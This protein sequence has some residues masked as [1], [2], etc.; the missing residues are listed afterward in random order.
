MTTDT[1][2]LVRTLAQRQ[3][4]V[5]LVVVV[6]T[7]GSLLASW[8]LI[9]VNRDD[10]ELINLAGRQRMLSQRMALYIALQRREPD[11]NKQRQYRA[12]VVFA[13]AEFER[14]LARLAAAARDHHPNSAIYSLYFGPSGNVDAECR[15]YLAEVR[16]VLDTLA[17]DK[18]ADALRIEEV[19]DAANSSLLAKLDE[20]TELHQ[21]DDETKEARLFLILAISNLLIVGTLAFGGLGVFRPARQRLSLDVAARDQAERDLKASEERF[22]AFSECSSD[23]FWE[24]D[25]Q[26]RFTWIR[27]TETVS[28]PL[29][30]EQVRGKTRYELIDEIEKANVEKWRAYLADVEAHRPFR[31][32]EYQLVGNDRSRRWMSVSGQPFFDAAGN[33]L[34]Y[35]GT[36]SYIQA[37]KEIEASHQRLQLAIEQSPVAIMITDAQ[38]NIIYVNAHFSSISGYQADEA[39]GRTPKLLWS[40]DVEADEF[41]AITADLAAGKVWR[42]EMCNRHKN[43]N[44][45]WESQ[46]ISPVCD[47]LGKVTHYILVSEDI[48]ARRKAVR[49]EQGYNRILAAVANGTPLRRTL[50]LMTAMAE[51]ELP[52][53]ICSFL[54]MDPTQKKLFGASHSAPD[55]VLARALDEL[56]IGEKV[57]ACGTAAYTG[58]EVLVDDIAAHPD[59][60]ACKGAA[61]ADGMRACWSKPILATTG[62]VLGVLVIHHRKPC[63]PDADAIQVIDL[64]SGLA[65]ICLERDATEQSIRQQEEEARGLLAEHQ[66]IL[67]NAMVGIVYLKQRRVVSCNRRLEEIFGYGHGELIGE[68]SRIFYASQEAFEKI[69]LDAYRVV[70]EGANYSTELTLKRKDGSY[71]RGALNGRAIDPAQPQE[72]SIWVYADISERYRAE[73]EAHK[74]LQAVEQSP[75][76]IMITDTNGLIEYANPRFTSVTG[77]SLREVVGQNPRIL[78]SGETRPDTYRELWQA[79]QAGREW[80]GVLRNRRKNGELF[81]EEAS[82]SPIIDDMNQVTNY[83]AVKEDITQRKHIEDEL[84][85]HRIN[86]EYLV[87]RRTADLTAALEAAKVADQA[88]D[89]F[90]ANVS[91]ELRTPLNA[92]IGMSDLA[93]RLSTDPKQQDYLDK[94]AGAGKTLAGIIND[95]L[96]LS[97]ISAGRMELEATGFSPRDLAARCGSV[98]E[99]RAAAK[100]LELL[101]SIGTDVPAVLLGDSLRIEQILLNLLS[102]AV[103]FTS[104]GR[105][106]LRIGVAARDGNRIQLN[107][108][109]EDTGIGLAEE[110]IAR[111]F[112]PFAQA[113]SSINRK[114][115]GTGL[116]LALCKRLAEMMDGGIGVTSREGIGT[117]FQVSLW[118]GLGSAADLP[119]ATEDQNAQALPASYRNA[120]VLVVDDQPLNREIVESLLALVGVTS[121]SAA[122]GQEALDIMSEAGPDAFDLVLMDIQM[123]VVDGL[124]ATRVIRKLDNFARLPIIAMTAHTMEHEKEI[125]RSAGMNDHIGKPF[126]TTRFLQVLS[127]WIPVEKH[128]M[129]AETKTPDTTSAATVPTRSDES[130]GASGLAALTSIDTQAGLARFVGNEARYRHW[131]GEF[132]KEAPGYAQ[133]IGRLIAAGQREA[134]RQAAHAIKG[135]VGMLGMSGLHSIVAALE[136][137]LKQGMPTDELLQS[138][139]A[140]VGP[141]CAEIQ[142]ALGGATATGPA[143]TEPAR[144]PSAA[145][146]ESIRRLLEMFRR[147]DGASAEALERCMTELADSDWLPLLRQALPLARN[148]DFEA[149]VELLASVGSDAR[150]DGQA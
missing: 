21:Q 131:L 82:I 8:R 101:T 57:G 74:L 70:A 66:T 135:R 79:L 24:T 88:K 37:R 143:K 20:V 98:M 42:G 137:A 35:R 48:T 116:G 54:R 61:A 86:L 17:S 106:E 49:R 11:Q 150:K 94:V 127:R 19:V 119:Q 39:I 85:Q 27:N 109:V 103:K 52:G 36:A 140:A 14:T 132:V 139:A 28:A 91:H 26:D 115:G 124:T 117:I 102:N 112:Q 3:W 12:K 2:A 25:A 18:P 136:T 90:L 77:Y 146:P 111:L 138:V 83:I 73:Q 38:R 104:T 65:A 87:E 113:D 144:R 84:E 134:A 93:R 72:G 50:D 30:L 43:G 78:K 46:S 75:V 64:I 44:L 10:A 4:A 105:V 63:S 80:R 100:G 126:D 45:Y 76:S 32:L 16:Q 71:F 142:A 96:D 89:A 56:D 5:S 6:L 23:W 60:H 147:S 51:A 145:M 67:N 148:F 107:I 22:K 110:S 31:N 58:R 121:V 59:C 92:V 114:F 55:S 133:D 41:A 149:A 69:G 108:E 7:L 68:S 120:R 122:N 118:L 9:E 129:Q 141:L 128:R 40:S 53:G 47:S 130:A 95:L 34:G 97:K 13:A 1:R 62:K 15:R 29:T 33:F 123:P 99:H 81:W 125:S